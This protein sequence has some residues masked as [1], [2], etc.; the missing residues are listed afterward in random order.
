MF[1]SRLL[2]L[3]LSHPQAAFLF[4]TEVTWNR[5]TKRNSVSSGT[6]SE[7]RPVDGRP[8]GGKLSHSQARRC[9]SRLIF[10]R[11]TRQLCLSSVFFLPHRSRPVQGRRPLDRVIHSLSL[12]SHTS[13][14]IGAHRLIP[15]THTH[16]EH[17]KEK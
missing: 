6:T 1:Q 11:S 17:R 15:L 16:N 7:T 5:M 3:F 2:S 8:T 13:E 4:L 12:L 14:S 10:V 9:S